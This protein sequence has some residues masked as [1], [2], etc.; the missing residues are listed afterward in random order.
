MTL[1]DGTGDRDGPAVRDNHI[2]DGVGLDQFRRWG[3][4][5]CG[6]HLGADGLGLRLGCCLDGCLRLGCGFHLV[7]YAHANG[8]CSF[9]RGFEL[10][11]CRCG[12]CGTCLSSCGCGCRATGGRAAALAPGLRL[13]SDTR[14]G[15]HLDGDRNFGERLDDHDTACLEGRVG[16]ESC[17]VAAVGLAP[18]SVHLDE[19]GVRLGGVCVVHHLSGTVAAAVDELLALLQDETLLALEELRSDLA[20]CRA[21][22]LVRDAVLD[23]ELEVRLA[24]RIAGSDVGDHRFV[25]HLRRGVG[26][27][28]AGIDAV[29]GC[30]CRGDQAEQP[31]GQQ[32]ADQGAGEALGGHFD[33][34][35]P[36][37]LRGGRFLESP[38]PRREG[39]T[40]DANIG[41]C[42]ARIYRHTFQEKGIYVEKRV[43]LG[44]IREQKLKR[45]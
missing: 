26:Y 20:H 7:E 17:V 44:Q 41:G 10:C 39:M 14:F 22:A 8:V 31:E 25:C 4:W 29:G 13:G 12:R 21:L 3:W 34:P 27:G 45:Y 28:G 6:L 40:I 15:D 24:H 19:L 11:L 30:G 36:S 18:H 23:D 16:L 2:V 35:F 38:T 1:G 5:R 43:S 33:L 9:D 37:F 32:Q 42:H